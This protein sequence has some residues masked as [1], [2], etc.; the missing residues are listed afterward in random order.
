MNREKLENLLT[1]EAIKETRV[2]TRFF[3]KFTTLVKVVI[4]YL[5]I[6][7]VV[8]IVSLISPFAAIAGIAGIVSA[9]K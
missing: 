4:C 1:S 9:A 3:S 8:A 2:R 7:A 6:K 5:I